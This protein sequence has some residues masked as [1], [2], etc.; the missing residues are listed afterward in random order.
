MDPIRCLMAVEGLMEA[1]HYREAARLLRTY[2]QWRNRGG[3]EPRLEFE[4]TQEAVPG[5]RFAHA[6]W[7]MIEQE[8][9]IASA[10]RRV[11]RRLMVESEEILR[12]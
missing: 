7:T 3:V 6:L 10:R 8:K 12:N 9:D 11:V 2:F 5:D 1:N 4:D